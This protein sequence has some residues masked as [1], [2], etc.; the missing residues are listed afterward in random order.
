MAV[1]N[2]EVVATPC[3]LNEGFEIMYCVDLWQIY[4]FVEIYFVSYYRMKFVPSIIISEVNLGSHRKDP[5][6]CFV[7]K[8]RTQSERTHNKFSILN[9]WGASW[10][11]GLFCS[12]G[13]TAGPY[14]LWCIQLIHLSSVGNFSSSNVRCKN[15]NLDCKLLSFSLVIPG[16][17]CGRRP[18]SV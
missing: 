7:Q 10:P 18:V 13:S 17:C 4:N 12:S 5:E 6:H 11:A 14:L 8:N 9:I 3:H 1:R 2:Y 16:K 15:E